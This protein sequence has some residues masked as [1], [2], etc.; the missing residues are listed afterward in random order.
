MSYIVC[1]GLGSVLNVPNGYGAVTEPEVTGAVIEFENGGLKIDVQ[2]FDNGVM[3]VFDD[4][5]N[6][7]N[8]YFELTPDQLAGD[9]WMLVRVSRSGSNLI[10]SVGN[11]EPVTVALSVT[12]TY[13]GKVT[14][15]KNKAG[16]LFDL[17]ILKKSIDETAVEYYLY[18]MAEN[19]GKSLLP[20]EK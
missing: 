7:I 4:G 19:S 5:D 10:L 1:R 15:M 18:D 6:Y 9:G 16:R 3:V 12:K 11:S 17:R 14:I 20:A 13:S 2:K 8:R